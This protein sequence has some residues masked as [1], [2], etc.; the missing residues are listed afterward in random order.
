M[1][2]RRHRFDAAGN[3][4]VVGA[5]GDLGGA[6]IDGVEAGGAEARD[7]HAGRLVVVAGLEGGRARDDGAGLADRIDAAEDDVVDLGRVEAV[8]VAQR[9]QHL[10]AEAHGRHL[11]Q[12]AI[13]LAAAAR[14]AH[15]V[16]DIGFGHF[17]AP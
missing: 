15:G 17:P 13:L 10:G 6:E 2:T 8:A 4:D 11:V 5:L 9:F 7:L 16:I 14:G 1:P 12:G 3:D